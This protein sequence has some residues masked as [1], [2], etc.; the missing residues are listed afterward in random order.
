MT[1]EMGMVYILRT[2]ETERVPKW[3]PEALLLVDQAGLTVNARC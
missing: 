2:S 1:S 3:S